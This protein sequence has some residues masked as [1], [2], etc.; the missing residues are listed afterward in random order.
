MLPT[1]EQI[2]KWSDEKIESVIN[3]GNAINWN[4]QLHESESEVEYYIECVFAEQ[5]AR[6]RND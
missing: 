5:E 2:E 6:K 1:Q 3:S 4:I